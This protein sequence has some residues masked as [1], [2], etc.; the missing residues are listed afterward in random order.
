MH[1]VQNMPTNSKEGSEHATD[2]HKLMP[3]THNYSFDPDPN[4]NQLSGN[5]SILHTQKQ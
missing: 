2:L 5:T 1:L 4:R 3:E